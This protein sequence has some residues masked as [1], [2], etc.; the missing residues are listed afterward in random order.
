VPDWAEDL[1]QRLLPPLVAGEGPVLARLREQAREV[2]IA[3]VVATGSGFFIRLTL[4]GESRAV[5]PPDFAG[6]DADLRVHGLRHGA[7]CVLHVREGRLALLELYSRGLEAWPES[8][9]I[10]IG[11]VGPIW[12]PR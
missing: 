2:V 7:D 5:Q 8:P 4:A 6:G 11:E 3:E 12:V 1:V 10:E 9:E